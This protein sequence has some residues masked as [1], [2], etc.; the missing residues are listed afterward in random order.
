MPRL[1]GVRF[2]TAIIERHR[3]RET[4]V[5]EAMIE[6]CLA[7]VSTRGIKDVSEIP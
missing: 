3:R 7:G 4:S 5:E 6:M 1:K 2:T